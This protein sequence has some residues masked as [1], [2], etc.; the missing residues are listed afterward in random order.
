MKDAS[1]CRSKIIN[2]TEIHEGGLFVEI[3][4]I[5]KNNP[6]RGGLFVGLENDSKPISHRVATCL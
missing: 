3:R 4:R 6:I 5:N 2:K 1:A